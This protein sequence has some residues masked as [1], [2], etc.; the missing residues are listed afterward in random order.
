MEATIWVA[1]HLLGV[2]TGRQQRLQ[3]RVGRGFA[4]FGTDEGQPLGHPVVV[5]VDGHGRD[6]QRTEKQRGGAGFAAHAADAFQ[7]GPGFGNRHFG[8]EIE[9]A[10]CIGAAAPADFAQHGLDARRLHAVQLCLEEVV[11]NLA[12]HASPEHGETVSVTVSIEADPLRV[13]VDDDALP[14]DTTAMPDPAGFTTLE[15][16]QI[17]GLGLTLVRSFSATQDYARIAGR[18]RLTL[19]FDGESIK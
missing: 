11:A 1:P 17:G 18:N 9:R 2:P 19:G 7:P 12:M 5:A 14:F 3:Q 15:E 10:R 16:A 4:H 6:A 13:M 8:Q